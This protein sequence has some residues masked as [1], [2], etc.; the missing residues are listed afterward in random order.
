MT[1]E[2]RVMR[3]CERLSTHARAS[4]PRVAVHMLLARKKRS[5]G[6][7]APTSSRSLAIGQ[8]GDVARRLADH[9][10]EKYWGRK[11]SSEY[12]VLHEFAWMLGRDFEEADRRIVERCLRWRTRPSRGI[13]CIGTCRRPDRLSKQD[14]GLHTRVS[15]TYAGTLR[16]P[17]RRSPIRSRAR[18]PT[19]LRPE[20]ATDIWVGRSLP[21]HAGA[22]GASALW[23]GKLSVSH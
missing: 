19:G 6:G 10:R 17:P 12:T 3:H 23:Q 16:G 1:K 13:A 20:R 11:T 21:F 2:L 4:A 18:D 14:A 5:D 8:S 7:W 22:E 15:A 9:E